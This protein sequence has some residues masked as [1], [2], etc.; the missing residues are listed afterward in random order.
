M[1]FALKTVVPW[2]RSFE[3]YVRM[4]A[5][6]KKDL[7]SRILGCADGPAGFNAQMHK[8][9]FRVVSCDPLYRYS[10]RS[11]RNRINRTYQK[12]LKQ[13]ETNQSDYV[14]KTFRDPKH[15]GRV[16]MRAMMIF[17]Q[18]FDQ[19][20]K[21]KR[22]VPQGLPCLPFKD[23]SFD[24]ALCSH[25]LFLYSRQLSLDFH[26]RSVLEMCRVAKEA[27]IFPLLDLG[28]QPSPYVKP[29]IQKLER[30]GFHT[31]IRKVRYE[32]Q[33]NGNKMLKVC[34]TSS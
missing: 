2:G 25:L 27:R 17:L 12:I 32:F 33:Q 28:G 3:E 7:E 1:A 34:K 26:L 21:E 6:K 10:V 22:Y 14:W 15:V 31:E 20:K 16:R 4:F 8:A 23:R 30:M 19:G 18:D 29:L 11:I 9:G 24:I 13:L 5:L